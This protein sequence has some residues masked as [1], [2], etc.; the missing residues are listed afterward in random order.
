MAMKMIYLAV[1]PAA[2]LAA[3]GLGSALRRVPVPSARGGPG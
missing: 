1:Y 2:V 3:L